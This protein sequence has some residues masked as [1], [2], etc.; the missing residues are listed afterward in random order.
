M[1]KAKPH[2]CRLREQANEPHRRKVMDARRKER[3]DRKK[4]STASRMHAG[5][6]DRRVIVEKTEKRNGKVYTRR[7][8]ATKGWR[9]TRE[10]FAKAEGR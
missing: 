4:A 9:T 8:H 2:P 5:E 10:F 6:F 7:Y 3:A 1:F